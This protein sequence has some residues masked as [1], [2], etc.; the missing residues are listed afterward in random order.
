VSTPMM[1]T[2]WADLANRRMLGSGDATALYLRLFTNAHNPTVDDLPS[3]F[4]ECNLPGY[5]PQALTYGNWTFSAANGKG[6]ATYPMSLFTFTS[7][8][9]AEQIYG[10][11]LT[12]SAFLKIYWAE[13]YDTPVIIPSTG[14]QWAIL[15]TYGDD[16]EEASGS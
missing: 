1:T 9:T 13:L 14:G 12:D 8:P 7:N 10:Y 15:L 5:S 4:T 16:Q 6:S 3:N 11:M 2:T